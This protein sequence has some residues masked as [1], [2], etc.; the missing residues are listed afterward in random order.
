MARDEGLADIVRRDHRYAAV[1]QLA[2][3][4]SWKLVRFI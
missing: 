3:Y 1:P 2:G 4:F